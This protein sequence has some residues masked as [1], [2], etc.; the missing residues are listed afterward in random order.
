MP[1]QH[2]SKVLESPVNPYQE[3][4]LDHVFWIF[5]TSRF[6]IGYCWLSV[7]CVE[8]D[9][10]TWQVPPPSRNDTGLLPLPPR[11]TTH[12]DRTHEAVNNRALHGLLVTQSYYMQLDAW[13]S[14][15]L[16]QYERYW[17]TIYWGILSLG[18][19]VANLSCKTPSIQRRSLMNTAE[20]VEW[21]D[22]KI[23][24]HRI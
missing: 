21:C 15:H 13:F 4:S 14:W 3:N 10:V 18:N 7:G 16:A 6:I 23:K 5:Q 11:P 22:P 20:S 17:Y 12:D 8:N 2:L 1:I 9:V 24:T 19:I